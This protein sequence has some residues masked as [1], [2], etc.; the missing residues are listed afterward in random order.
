VETIEK[1]RNATFTLSRRG[2]DR[3][4]VDS[5]LSKLADWLQGGG[6]NQVHSDTIKAELDRIG[7]NTSKILTAAQEAADS[8]CADAQNQAREIVESSRQEIE[9]TRKAADEYAKKAREEAQ[10]I[11]GKARAEAESHSKR[12]RSEAEAHSARVRQ[13]A[14]AYTTKHHDEADGYAKRVRSEAD[15]HAAQVR[16]EADAHAS[17]AVSAAEQKA[18][19]MVEEATKRRREIEKVIADLQTRREAVVKGLEKLSSQL[20]GAAT[21]GMSLDPRA[22]AKPTGVTPSV[23]PPTNAQHA[24][25]SQPPAPTRQ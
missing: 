19:A 12:I 8:L 2:Y 21:E 20:A 9:S 3:R 1:I 13:E 4:E 10:G 24:T 17:Q 16:S 14:D 23:S 5:Y 11:A 22:D 6:T 7:R 15:A 18:I 25:N